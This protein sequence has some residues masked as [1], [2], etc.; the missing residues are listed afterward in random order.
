ML[1]TMAPV[2]LKTC[3]AMVYAHFAPAANAAPAWDWLW[4]S[5][6]SKTSVERSSWTIINLTVNEARPRTE[7]AGGFGGN[8]RGGRGPRRESRW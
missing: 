3:S 2:F 6:L 7:R 1:S 5:V 4:Y 8:D